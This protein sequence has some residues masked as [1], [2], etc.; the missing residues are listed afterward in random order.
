MKAIFAIVWL[1][2]KAAVRYRLMLVM[3][4]LLFAA[5]T[6][7]PLLIK[8]IGTAQAFTQV[9]L[10]YTLTAITAVLGFSTLWLACGTLAR[11][12]EECQLQ[13]V[14]VKPIAR[15][16]IWIGKWLGIM[17]LNTI[18]LAASGAAVY[19]LLMWRVSHLPEQQ[20]VI[21]R[22][23]VLVS[24]GS[25]KEAVPNLD[26]E[27][28]R[29]VAEKMRDNPTKITDEQTM[30][31]IR[32]QIREM[33]KS[34]M[35]I[36]QQNYMR[37]WELNLGANKD[38]LRG[39]TLFLRVKFSTVEA[40]KSD[41][42]RT[43][44]LQWYIGIPDTSRLWRQEFRLASDSFQEF[45]IPPDLFDEN[46]RIVVECRNPNEVNILFQLED[47]LELLYRADGF[48]VNYA[49]GLFILLLWLGLLAAIGL[50][51]ASFLSFPV[52]SFLALCILFIG[53]SNKT[54]AQV[55]EEGGISGVNHNTGT[56]DV[57]NVMDQ[58]VVFFFGSLLKVV[59]LVEGFS[60]VDSLS[61]GREISWHQL[62]QAFLNIIGILGGIFALL[63]IT[64]FTRRELATAQG[65]Q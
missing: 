44:P 42:P 1:T 17:L 63:G 25:I 41:E 28:D 20:Q 8:D 53:F 62:G 64:L 15:W 45:A 43:Y 18:L 13:M 51:S 58:T 2:V 35:Q 60:P 48:G 6:A 59:K 36:V 7:L 21:L 19:A 52:A 55:V 11:E 31:F 16:Q 10:T 47:G 14:V 26:L 65:T 40:N 39:Q 50:A 3:G 27:V 22:N 33:I 56:I 12:V 61:T 32:D 57:P 49:R 5:V 24:R 29:I 46:G 54:L 38:K 30:R 4:I 34:P 23:E 9:L 37:R